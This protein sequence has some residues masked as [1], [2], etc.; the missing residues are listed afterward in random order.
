MERNS[1][2]DRLCD[3]EDRHLHARDDSPLTTAQIYALRN[4]RDCLRH[5]TDVF[6][7]TDICF[8][9]S[10]VDS[11]M[12]QLVLADITEFV[13]TARTTGIIDFLAVI[14]KRGWRVLGPTEVTRHHTEWTGMEDESYTV[15][16][17]KV[18]LG[19]I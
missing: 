5:N 18:K 8:S 10:E 11:F 15:S 19:G 13:L 6:E 16:G 12:E 17:L 1:Y 9:D 2:F 4:Y 7:V 14:A 3:V